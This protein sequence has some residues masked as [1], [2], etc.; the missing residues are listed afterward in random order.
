VQERADAVDEAGVITGEQL[1]RDEGGAA[2]RRALIVEAAAE[3][4]RLLPVPELADRAI[5]HRPLAVVRGPCRRFQLV[6][7]ARA[8]ACQL[9]LLAAL[10]ER[11]RFRRG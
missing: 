8:E 10:R 11:G 5:R 1:Q 9:T 2:A 6:L 4:L 3:Q 7:P